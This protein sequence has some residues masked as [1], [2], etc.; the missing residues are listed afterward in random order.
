MAENEISAA[1]PG[2]LPSRVEKYRTEAQSLVELGAE[3]PRCEMKRELPISNK[4]LKSK[5]SFVKLIQGM[6]NAHLTD[7]RFIIIGADQ[8]ERKFHCVQ[9]ADEFDSA[10]L[11]A[12]LSKYLDPLP[13]FEAFN[14]LTAKD[15]ARFVLIVLAGS[16][17]RP[18]V[19][20]ANADADD[21]S[22]HIRTGEIWIKENAGLRLAIREDLE[23]MYRGRIDAEAES[24]SRYRFTVLRDELTAQLKV[25]LSTGPRIPTKDV[26]FGK[27][28][29]FR[30]FVEELYRAS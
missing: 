7:E 23:A 14:A 27:D 20:K 8:K 6:A 24:R 19:I 28:E 22:V 16:Q 13:S 25:G 29:D 21:G 12:I 9:N 2:S 10:N 5:L 3:H 18:I 17:P 26:L 1:R 30:L 4:S 15:G 11:S